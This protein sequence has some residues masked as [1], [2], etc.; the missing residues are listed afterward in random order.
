MLL[1]ASER[2]HQTKSIRGHRKLIEI[3][4]K[5]REV[6]D[7]LDNMQQELSEFEKEIETYAKKSRQNPGM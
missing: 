3:Q 5:K 4:R 2:T 6:G 1:I 7:L